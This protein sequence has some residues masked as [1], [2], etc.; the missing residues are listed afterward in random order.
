M[1]VGRND[2]HNL[3]IPY[4]LTIFLLML[5]TKE[6]KNIASSSIGRGEH[7][8]DIVTPLWRELVVNEFKE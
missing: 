6:A 1:K 7:I 3:Y 8:D 2:E 4:T 5:G